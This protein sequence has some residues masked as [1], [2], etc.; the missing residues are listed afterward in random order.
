MLIA[1][2]N[3]ERID[4]ARAKRGPD[5][6]CPACCEIVVLKQGRKVI[7]HFAHKP[8]ISC[9]SANGET[10]AHLE[11]KALVHSAL[12]G[13]GLKAEIEFSVSTF[14]GDRR[15][16]VMAWSPKNVSIAFE[17]QHTAID[18]DEIEARASS[19]G[20]AGIAQIWIPFLKSS[21]WKD[22]EPCREGWFVERY[23]PRPFERWVH[24]FGGKHGMWM[25]DPAKKEFW[26]GRMAGHQTYVEEKSWYSEGGEENYGG[27]FHRWS[28]RYKEL[29]LTGPHKADELL[30]KIETRKK[31]NGEGF[32]WPAGL[33]ARL[34]PRQITR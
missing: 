27:G 3:G 31:F 9:S 1:D 33:I 13:R 22:G 23:S 2:L 16:D 15:S 18:L 21:V 14:R 29:T 26:L 11:A 10:R 20:H 8:P 5:Y 34:I 6:R 4:A 12:I 17:L 25:Y 32:S 7:E 19:Y 30:I 24:G 28:K